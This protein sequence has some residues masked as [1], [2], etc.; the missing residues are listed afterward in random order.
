MKR[1]TKA[2]NYAREG[3]TKL[4]ASKRGMR[5]K[6]QPR[7]RLPHGEHEGVYSSRQAP[8]ADLHRAKPCRM[9]S[10]TNHRGE[11][12]WGVFYGQRTKPQ[13]FRS[14]EAAEKFQIECWRAHGGVKGLGRMAKKKPAKKPAKKTKRKKASA[15]SRKARGA[16]C[17]YTPSGK[18]FNCFAERS[19]AERVVKGMNK[20]CQ[21]RGKPA[22]WS[23]RSSGR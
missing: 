18:L 12:R 23:L 22:S 2:G 14:R 4:P 20:G 5:R 8:A 9:T 3:A 1:T 19:S 6:A 13:L 11:K 15:A 16:H 10:V 17:V 21:K 7:R